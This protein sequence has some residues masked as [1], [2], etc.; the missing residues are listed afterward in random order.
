MKACILAVD[1]STSATKALL[2]TPEGRMLDKESRE[3]RQHYPRPGWVEHDA[4]EIWQ[5]TLTTLG[6]IAARN[7]ELVSR[8]LC[9]SITNQR[10]TIVVFERG[11][12][13]P[14]CRALVW[15]DR[16]GDAICGE[17]EKQGRG[18]LVAEC[19]GLRLDAYFSGSKLLWLAREHPELR[20]KMEK[21]EALV[22]T[23]DAYLVYRLTQGRV[24]ACD[25][26]NASRTLLFDIARLCWSEELC[27]LWG[28][29]PCALPEVRESSACFGETTLDGRLARALPIRGVMGDSQASLFAQRCFEAGSAKVTF[30]TGSSVLLNIGS[31]MKRSR[32]GLITALAWVYQ[33]RPTYAFEGII[34]SSAS[35]LTWLRD[36]LGVIADL[37]EVE[38]MA[39][40]LPGNEGVYL[41]P[42]FSGLGLPHW[43]PAARAAIVGMSSQTDRRHLVRAALESISYQLRDALDAMR[44]EAGVSLAGIHA[45]GGPTANRFLMQFTSDIAGV[46]LQVASMPDCSALGAVL[47]G[48]LGLG[49]YSSLEEIAGQPRQD[50]SFHPSP[51]R[52]SAKAAYEGW[53]TAVGR[54]MPAAKN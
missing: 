4:E 42:A 39:R 47:S 15:Q 19:T 7:P 46:E 32:K 26:T 8:A 50:A 11:S 45:D 38:A 21:G 54:V 30:G 25:F 40:S 24:F 33:G 20:A 18:E 27:A 31:S 14:L 5:N 3:H 23:I 44:A 22:G 52:D 16:R 6:A 10:E 12:G 9:L 13:K 49:Y 53:Q 41:V 48:L 34:I 28:V 29:P 17:M 37:S 35:T 43:Q 2:L 51:E 36:Q 1:Q